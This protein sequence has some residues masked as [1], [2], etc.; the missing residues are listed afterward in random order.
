[1]TIEVF[2]IPC[3]A[4]TAEEARMVTFEQHGR[5]RV[6]WVRDDLDAVRRSVEDKRARA[7]ENAGLYSDKLAE[8]DATL[9]RIYELQVSSDPTELTLIEALT[10]NEDVRLLDR[11]RVCALWL[12]GTRWIVFGAV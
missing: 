1:V 2:K 10:L 8:Y 3:K 7:E 6:S 9:H 11:S 4:E 5:D 12:G